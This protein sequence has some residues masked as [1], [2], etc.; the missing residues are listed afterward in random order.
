MKADRKDFQNFNTYDIK[1]NEAQFS[2]EAVLAMVN[3]LN[4]RNK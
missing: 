2:C 1:V 4:I 3:H